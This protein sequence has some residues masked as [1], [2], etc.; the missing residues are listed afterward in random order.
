MHRNNKKEIERRKKEYIIVREY[1]IGDFYYLITV[2]WD[3]RNKDKELLSL[4]FNIP[5]TEFNND[6]FV[7]SSN[8]PWDLNEPGFFFDNSGHKVWRKA[9]RK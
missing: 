2:K 9:V 4:H 6:T 8:C 5:V 7:S 1:Q 3:E